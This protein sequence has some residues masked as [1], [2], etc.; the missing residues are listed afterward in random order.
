[1]NDNSK[2]SEY[3]AEITTALEANIP[4]IYSNGFSIILGTGDVIILLKE[5]GINVATLNL[6]YTVAK[7]LS[8]KLGGVIKILEN[9]T[10]NTIMTTEDIE[11]SIKGTSNVKVKK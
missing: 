10:G 8:E 5:V 4:H 3:N 7:T 9:K 1:M 2:R 6:S 11:K